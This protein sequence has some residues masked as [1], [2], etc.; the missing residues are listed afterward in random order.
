[1]SAYN[2]RIWQNYLAPQTG[3]DTQDDPTITAELR[4]WYAPGVANFK[5]FEN[6]QV[7]DFEG[8]RGRVLS[9]SYSPAPEDHKYAPMLEELGTIFQAH[10][11][12]GKVSIDYECRVCY[13]PL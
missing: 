5:S 8:L 4:A 1:M 6:S 12:N 9:S 7:V 11:A 13:G 3:N 10:Q 2:Q